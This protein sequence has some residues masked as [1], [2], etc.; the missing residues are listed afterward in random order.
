MHAWQ[1]SELTRKSLCTEYAYLF[2]AIATKASEGLYSLHTENID[3]A[4]IKQSALC[5][6]LE[7]MGYQVDIER[8][9]ARPSH[10]RARFLISWVSIPVTKEQ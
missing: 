1:A 3:M 6:L 5:R 7:S 9:I 2:E 4:F 8:E 10:G